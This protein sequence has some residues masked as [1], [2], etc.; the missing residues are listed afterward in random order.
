LS[1][2]VK[3]IGGCRMSKVN[4]PPT[5]N[6]DTG[7][8]ASAQFVA[9]P[10]GLF[11]FLVD[12]GTPSQ[13]ADH[14]NL[15]LPAIQVG[16]G[17]GAESSHVEL[18]AGPGVRGNWLC[19]RGDA[20]VAK[21]GAS[22][23]ILLTTLR[24]PGGETLS[25]EVRRL[26]EAGAIEAVAAAPQIERIAAPGIGLHAIAHVRLRGDLSYDQTQWI[27]R[28]GKGMWIESFSLTPTEVLAA[29]DLEYKGL[30]ASGVET[31]W[32]SNGTFCGTRGMATP[33]IGFAIRLKSDARDRYDCE[34]SGYFHSGATVGPFKNGQPCRSVTTDDPLEGFM[35]R[36]VEKSA[37]G[38]VAAVQ[39]SKP[40]NKSN[41]AAVVKRKRGSRE[42]R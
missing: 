39:S 24:A 26:D 21:V 22:T 18:V 2:A 8:S 9:L 13:R 19:A 27:G 17:P 32:V 35:L 36:I 11:L 16:V 29:D 6:E 4:E 14:Q 33:L 41:E 38:E 40:P 37:A 42:G 5:A 3:K 25:L 7:L 28:A 20:I 31:P 30:T 34:Y 15:F 1:V 12:S 10:P 23:N